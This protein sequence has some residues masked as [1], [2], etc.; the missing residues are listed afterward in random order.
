MESSQSFRE[1]VYHSDPL[2]TPFERLLQFL[3]APGKGCLER[4][5][6]V[7]WLNLERCLLVHGLQAVAES[8]QR[9]LVCAGMLNQS[10]S[11]RFT[12]KSSGGAT[13]TSQ[14]TQ[15]VVPRR[16]RIDQVIDANFLLLAQA[17]CASRGLVEHKEVHWHL[18]PDHGVDPALQVEAF[19]DTPVRN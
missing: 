3:T 11:R 6:L 13:L 7:L 12:S 10:A 8:C 15:L 9:G 1:C 17:P 4:F 14:L 2:P 16:A 19:V 18:E 5:G